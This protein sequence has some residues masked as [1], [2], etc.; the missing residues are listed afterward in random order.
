MK[1]TLAQIAR[2]ASIGFIAGE[3]ALLVYLLGLILLTSLL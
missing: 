1:K 2:A 3:V